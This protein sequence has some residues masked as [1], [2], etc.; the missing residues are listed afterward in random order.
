MKDN[1]K[2]LQAEQQLKE[3]IERNMT[4]VTVVKVPYKYGWDLTV[5]DHTPPTE[6]GIGIK[7]KH[8]EVKYA[9]DTH[10]PYNFALEVTN[11]DDDTNSMFKHQDDI[12]YLAYLSESD[13]SFYIYTMKN[14]IEFYNTYRHTRR[15]NCFG[16]AHCI[17]LP[18]SDASIII[19]NTL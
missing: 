17:L 5:I 14:I 16:T 11:A 19:S 3:L 7:E 1:I 13:N 9:E 10:Y 4:N 8:L 18:K 12:D 2:G 6:S 15:L